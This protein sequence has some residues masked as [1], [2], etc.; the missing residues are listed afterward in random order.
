LSES[1]VRI[2]DT[3]YRITHPTSADALIDETDFDRNERL[4]Y[5]AELWPSAIALARYLYGRELTGTRAIELGCGV[6]LPT[7]AALA[8]GARMLATDHYEAALDFAIHNAYTNLGQ[9]LETILLDW[10]TPDI[11]RLGTFD[12]AIGADVLYERPN[13]LA[14]ADLVPNLLAPEGEAIFA[15]PR[16]D[17][18][19]TFLAVMKERGFENDTR[20]ATVEQGGREV[21]VLLHRLRRR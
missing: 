16:R 6:G 15:D 12:L 10:R 18:A 11:Q 21:R 3:S 5:W 9:A 14:L 1:H 17:S 13:A 8:R 2:G 7:V 4:P 19:P 20:S